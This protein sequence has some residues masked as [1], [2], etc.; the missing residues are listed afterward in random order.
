M[1]FFFATRSSMRRQ[2]GFLRDWHSLNVAVS[3]AMKVLVMIGDFS[4]LCDGALIPFD[5]M[6][7]STRRG[8]SGLSYEIFL[9]DEGDVRASYTRMRNTSLRERGIWGLL[10]HDNLRLCN[11]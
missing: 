4:T 11:R 7:E 6:M 8:T 10:S 1:V 3:R 5:K 2:V 9:L